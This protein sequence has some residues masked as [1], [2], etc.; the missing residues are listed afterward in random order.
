[1]TVSNLLQEARAL[2]ERGWAQEVYSRSGDNGTEY[3]I[4]GALQKAADPGHYEAFQAAFKLLNL[5]TP[6]SP[7]FR[8]KC[9]SLWNDRSGRTK[10]EVL[11]LFD[12]A[13]TEV[14]K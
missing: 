2:I 3:C 13:L 1:M 5:L 10:Q 14:T 11:A 8:V 6:E 7:G 12:R 4:V 9:C